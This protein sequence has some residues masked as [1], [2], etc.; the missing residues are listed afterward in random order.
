MPRRLQKVK[1]AV[2]HQFKMISFGGSKQRESL[3][4]HLSQSRILGTRAEVDISIDA[5]IKRED[6]FFHIFLAYK[7]MNRWQDEQQRILCLQSVKLNGP[8]RSF[9]IVNL[10][11]MQGPL[12]SSLEKAGER[13]LWER[14]CHVVSHDL[15]QKRLL[16]PI[17]IQK[18]SLKA[19]DFIFSF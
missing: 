4:I 16:M 7:M 6:C 14:G 9:L 10:V 12:A 15:T 11:P 13:G 1:F 8:A 5:E 17:H 2:F 19:M 3:F 18:R